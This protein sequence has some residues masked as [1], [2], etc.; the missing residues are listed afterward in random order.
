MGRQKKG[1]KEK[2][3]PATALATRVP[4]AS[5]K[6]RLATGT[7]FAQTPLRRNPAPCCDARRSQGEGKS[8]ATATPT[9]EINGNGNGNSNGTATANSPHTS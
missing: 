7:R 5:R 1:T 9:P 4:C 8:K 2:A 6:A 3:T